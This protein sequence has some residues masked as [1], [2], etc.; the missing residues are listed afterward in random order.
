MEEIGADERKAIALYNEYKKKHGFDGPKPCQEYVLENFS[1]SLSPA[2]GGGEA[3]DELGQLELYLTKARKYCSRL[4]RMAQLRQSHYERF[5]RDVP[6]RSEDNGHMQRRMGMN[7]AAS[8][9]KLRLQF[10]EGQREQLLSNAIAQFDKEPPKNYLLEMYGLWDMEEEEEGKEEEEEEEKKK[11]SFTK[12]KTKANSSTSSPLEIEKARR[13]QIAFDRAEARITQQYELL[14]SMSPLLTTTCTGI[15]LDIRDVLL[16][17][18]F[19]NSQRVEIFGKNRKKLETCRLLFDKDDTGET[20]TDRTQQCY[21]LVLHALMVPFFDMETYSQKFLATREMLTVSFFHRSL[22][23]KDIPRPKQIRLILETLYNTAYTQLPPQPSVR[24]KA[25]RFAFIMSGA[26]CNTLEEFYL[27]FQAIHQGKARTGKQL[28]PCNMN[29][30][31]SMWLTSR[32]RFL[33]FF[34]SWLYDVLQSTD[35]P[36][37]AYRLL[38]TLEYTTSMEKPWEITPRRF[39]GIVMN[40]DEAN[41]NDLTERQQKIQ[42]LLRRARKGRKKK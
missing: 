40:R 25:G 35:D 20:V 4:E 17:I 22:N 39:K 2:R 36:H 18:H 21:R 23:H 24:H 15:W 5:I 10:W 11:K 38:D 8:N 27:Y 31:I 30:I 13:W 42:V 7:M 28:S 12:G 41:I 16:S 33:T 34:A 1:P 26:C 3:G 32:V 6:G 37:E 29:L 14:V 19:A 9:S